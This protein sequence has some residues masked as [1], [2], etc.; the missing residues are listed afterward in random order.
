MGSAG[1]RAGGEP[2]E[3]ERMKIIN[4][5]FEIETTAKIYVHDVT[6]RVASAVSSSAVDSGHV[7]VFSP[8]TTVALT[9]N[10]N[11]ER[12][13][14]DLKTHLCALVPESRHYGHDDIHLRDVPPNEPK[15]AR[16]HL[17][18]M[19]LGQSEVIPVVAGR[20]TLGAWQ[21]ILMVELDGPRIRTLRLQISGE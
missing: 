13:F 2:Y 9:I 14:E 17:M 5:T 15:N 1:V 10:E 18:A 7:I 8:H 6:S 3:R 12:L 4:Q 19:L 11:E 21:S 20:L 16:A